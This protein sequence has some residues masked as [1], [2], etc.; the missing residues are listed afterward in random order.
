MQMKLSRTWEAGLR[1]DYF[2]PDSIPYAADPLVLLIPLAYPEEDAYR[3][4]VGP[5]V[6]WHQSPFVRYR[7]EYNHED[8]RGMEEAADRIMMQLIFAA[9]PHK[10]ERY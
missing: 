8:G 7:L 2:N 1:L 5:Y 10:H 3:W 6:T 9:G 4:G